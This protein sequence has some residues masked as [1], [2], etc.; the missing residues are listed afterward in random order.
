M[1]DELPVCTQDRSM[2]RYSHVY[3]FFFFASLAAD[4]RRGRSFFFLNCYQKGSFTILDYPTPLIRL[5]ASFR[6]VEEVQ[7]MRLRV[8]D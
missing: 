5:R 6:E 8:V 7:S 1:H 3:V 2:L 4:R